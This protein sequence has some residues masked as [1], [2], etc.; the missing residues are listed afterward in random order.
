M[1]YKKQKEKGD[2]LDR[3]ESDSLFLEKITKAYDELIERQVWA[4]W[5]PVDG[6]RS[7]EEVFE[8][9]KKILRV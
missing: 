7:K 2:N 6:E 3:I 8:Q 4:S 9:I 5:F 1:H